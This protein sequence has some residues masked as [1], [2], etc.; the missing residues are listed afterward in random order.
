VWVIKADGTGAHALTS[1][2]WNQESP[3]WSPDGRSIAY[4]SDQG[5]QQNIWTIN[6][7][8]SGQTQLTRGGGYR[9]TPSWQPLPSP[10]PIAPLSAAATT[11]PSRPT[12][13][14]RLVAVFFRA[15]SDLYEDVSSVFPSS[16][17][18]ALTVGSRLID[19]A[20]AELR[21]TLAVAPT[22]NWARRFKRGALAM[23]ASADAAGHEFNAAILDG[24]R[25]HKGPARHDVNA[26]FEDIQ[27]M[28]TDEGGLA[29][30]L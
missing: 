14:A 2:P 15:E 1:G 12:P 9:I 30:V 7:D 22:T 27:R 16:P 6:A 28:F 10:A 26:A 4:S 11:R 19:N 8:G 13:E 20:T 23:Y 18:A 5:Y 17:V 25:G 29:S 24:V 3:A 21:Q